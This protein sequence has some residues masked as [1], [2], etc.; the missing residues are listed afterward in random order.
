MIQ[1]DGVRCPHVTKIVFVRKREICGA[2][3]Q[4]ARVPRFGVNLVKFDLVHGIYVSVRELHRI[5]TFGTF[6]N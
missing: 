2:V 4:L 6:A 5:D 1:C 3:G